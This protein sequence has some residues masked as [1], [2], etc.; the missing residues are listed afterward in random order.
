MVTVID[1]CQ[2]CQISLF[3][4]H[5]ICVADR[6]PLWDQRQ[7]IIKLLAF[8]LTH[9]SVVLVQIGCCGNN[10]HQIQ[11]HYIYMVVRDVASQNRYA[12]FQC[13]VRV[14]VH[15]THADRDNFLMCSIVNACMISD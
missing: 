13:T 6:C 7:D 9:D 14:F 1:E 10:P 8:K 5:N 11:M 4:Q 15:L 12:E 2:I 3:Y